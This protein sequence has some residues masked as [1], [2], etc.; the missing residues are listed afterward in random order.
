[1]ELEN[2]YPW[3]CRQWN[4]QV[5]ERTEGQKTLTRKDRKWHERKDMTSCPTST[6]S[7]SLL[8]SSDHSFME[9]HRGKNRQVTVTKQ[10]NWWRAKNFYMYKCNFI[11]MTAFLWHLQCSYKQQTD[12]IYTAKD[13]KRTVR[14]KLNHRCLLLWKSPF[15]AFRVAMSEVIYKVAVFLSSEYRMHYSQMPESSFK[16][17]LEWGSKEITNKG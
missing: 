6:T 14:K 2:R 4:G 16:I 8:L 1:M 17:Q 3:H 15:G 12:Q 11:S 13:A 9:I 7:N 10:C 5:G